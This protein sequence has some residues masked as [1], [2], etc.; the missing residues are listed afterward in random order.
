MMQ[1]KIAMRLIAQEKASPDLLLEPLR[2]CYDQGMDGVCNTHSLF[3]ERVCY[4]PIPCPSFLTVA[5]SRSC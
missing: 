3:L 2:T 1:R 5:G 4:T